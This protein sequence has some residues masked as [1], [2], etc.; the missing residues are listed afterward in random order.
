EC[1]VLVE[2]GE[3]LQLPKGTPG[4]LPC[5]KR[6]Q[7][8]N[9]CPCSATDTFEASPNLPVIAPVAVLNPKDRELG[10]VIRPGRLVGLVDDQFPD[11]LVEGR[12]EIVKDLPDQDAPYTWIEFKDLDAKDQFPQVRVEIANEFIRLAFLEVGEF[13]VQQ[14]KLLVCAT[15]FQPN[16]L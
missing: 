1:A 12:P 10:L 16:A 15:E 8:L 5:T 6:L 13:S 14:A 3:F 9:L 11:K 2:V 7:P 4:V